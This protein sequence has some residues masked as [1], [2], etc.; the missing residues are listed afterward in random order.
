MVGS[1]TRP[2]IELKRFAKIHLNP[3]ETKIIQFELH[4]DDLKYYNEQLEHLLELGMFKVF[5]GRNAVETL[6]AGFELK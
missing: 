6:E 3:G 1:N 5:V 2:S 4:T